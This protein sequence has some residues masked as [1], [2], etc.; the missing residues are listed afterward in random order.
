VLRAQVE[1]T[2][3]AIE[4]DTAAFHALDP[5]YPHQHP[6]PA[7]LRAY[8][9]TCGQEFVDFA[10]FPAELQGNFIKVR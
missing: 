7:G 5:P 10:S 3:M 6:A 9:G 4:A 8:S 2:H 1:L